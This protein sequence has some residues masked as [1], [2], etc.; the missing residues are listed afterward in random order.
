MNERALAIRRTRQW[1]FLATAIAVGLPAVAFR[2]T[3]G[4]HLDP[5]LESLVFGAGIVGAAF[6]LAWAADVAQL[7]I[8][9][10]LALAIV[11]LVAVLPEYA[12]DFYLTWQAGQDP[13]GPY[14]HYATANMTGGNRLL[15]GIG[16][17]GVALLYWAR[18]RRGLTLNRPIHLEMVALI[19]ATLIAFAIP[20]F[21]EIALWAT[22]CLLALFA[23]YLWLQSK[24]E[25]E[26]PELVGPADLIGSFGKKARRGITVGLT[27]YAALVIVVAAEPFAEGL[28]DTGS[29]LGVDEFFL[30]QWV[31][32]L[33]SEAP[34]LLIAV[35]LVLRGN[36]T[37]A[38]IL[39]ISAKVNQWTLLIGSLPLVFSVSLG[40]ASA[41]PLDSRQSWEILLTAAQSLFAVVLLLRMRLGPKGALTLLVLFATQLF[42]THDLVRHIYAFIYIGLTVVVLVV[43]PGRLTRFFHMVATV[44][45][46]TS[47]RAIREVSTD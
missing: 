29:V 40:Q 15:I 47:G 9:Q 4:P 11:A 35:L 30:I 14:V 7:D 36:A 27:I 26:V 1:V 18:H 28:I 10:G 2:L 34:E 17:S 45:K 5:W 20:V 31:A 16:W 3:G 46:S 6:L 22:G 33:A 37:G 39:L 25:A 23:G 44:A 38:L 21:R 32:P 19:A 8:S 12:V 43:D 41:L 24:E 42:L 13:L